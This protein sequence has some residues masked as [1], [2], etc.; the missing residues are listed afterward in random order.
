[1]SRE[2]DG[3]ALEV[4]E[5]VDTEARM[6]PVLFN[7]L[8]EYDITSLLGWDELN[9]RDRIEKNPWI[10]KHCRM[11]ALQEE[12]KLGKVQDM[13][14]KHV[15]ELYHSLKYESGLELTKTE[16]ERYYIPKD[17]RVCELKEIL[18]TQELVVGYWREL[19]KTLEHQHWA[20]RN[21]VDSGKGGY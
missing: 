15:G 19:V 4:L 21:W 16:I 14:D 10:Q 3:K 18:R 20:L 11:K 8:T 5:C 12:A 2:S 6:D 13:F 9:V 7:L 1:M 17:V